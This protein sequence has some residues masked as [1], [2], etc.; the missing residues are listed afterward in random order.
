MSS[1]AFPFSAGWL[2]LSKGNWP[3]LT[4]FALNNLI[5]IIFIILLS[6]KV[7]GNAFNNLFYFWMLFFFAI[8][9]FTKSLL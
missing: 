8:F 1:T 6:F 3:V 2:Y 4:L 5:I 9:C 7:H